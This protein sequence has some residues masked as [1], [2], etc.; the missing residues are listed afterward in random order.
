MPE[1]QTEKVLTQDLG[2]DWKS[3]FSRFDMKPFAAASI[4]QVH[5]AVLSPDSPLYSKYQQPRR[6][7]SKNQKE[8]E[9]EK[10]LKV[11]VKVQF[12]GVRESISSD[13]SNLKWLLMATAVLPRGL[14]LDNSLKV[15]ERE[16]IQECDYEREAYFGTKM[17]QL[18]EGSKLKENFDVPKVIEEL[19]GKMVLTTEMMFGKPL[20]SVMNLDQDRRDWVNH[21]LSLSI[22]FDWR[23]SSELTNKI[24]IIEKKK[25]LS[26]ESRLVLGF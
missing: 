17:G 24:L 3:H 12:P 23:E 10:G 26:L 22:S 13:L 19:S 1:W 16:L 6:Q 8:K 4:G 20:K 21:V 15:L 11:A 5:S 7:S 14:Y 9:K 25:P 18:V 2:S